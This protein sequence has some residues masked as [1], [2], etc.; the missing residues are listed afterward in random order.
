MPRPSG[1][2]ASLSSPF[3]S[4]ELILPHYYHTHTH[5]HRRKAGTQYMSLGGASGNPRAHTLGTGCW[6]QILLLPWAPLT[7]GFLQ[8]PLPCPWLW[9]K[10]NCPPYGPTPSCSKPPGPAGGLSGCSLWW[11]TRSSGPPHL[12][13]RPTVKSSLWARRCPIVAS[14]LG[15][16]ASSLLVWGS[17]VATQF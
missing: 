8:C 7:P 10:G 4:P 14:P 9:V 16:R 1:D 5:T 6:V 17:W 12:G 3:S 13:R 15:L 2:A 11:P